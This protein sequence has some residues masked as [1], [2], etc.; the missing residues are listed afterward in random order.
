M[1]KWKN[2]YYIITI[3]LVPGL[4]LYTFLVLVPVIQAF[5]LSTFKWTT[6][7]TKTFIGLQNYTELL[8]KPQGNI[9]D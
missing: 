3:F 6:L 1:T 8:E 4:A 9:L 7:Y 2:N 5:Y